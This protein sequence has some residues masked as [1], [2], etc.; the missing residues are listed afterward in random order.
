MIGEDGVFISKDQEGLVNIIVV[1]QGFEN[2]TDEV[3]VRVVFPSHLDLEIA[4]VTS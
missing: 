2:N 3:S 4:D 1:E